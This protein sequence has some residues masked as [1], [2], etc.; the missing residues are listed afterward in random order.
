MLPLKISG[1]KISGHSKNYTN[2]EVQQFIYVVTQGS[3]R[4]AAALQS[5]SIFQKEAAAEFKTVIKAMARE[6]NMEE[7]GRGRSMH[8]E[9][10]GEPSDFYKNIIETEKA[11]LCNNTLFKT[12]VEN[13]EFK[14][15]FANSRNIK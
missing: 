13:V 10:S 6:E 8:A 5:A 9:S 4:K 1:C 7:N 3:S 12:C 2:L 15:S 14:T 11:R